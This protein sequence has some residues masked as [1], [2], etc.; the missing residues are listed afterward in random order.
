MSCILSIETSTNICSVAMGNDGECIFNQENH[1][2][3]NHN[4]ILGTFI[5]EALTFIDARNIKLDAVA[6]SSGPGSYT[7]LRI[8]AS[9]AKGICYGRDAKLIAVPTLELL[10]VPVLL[11]EQ[12]AEDDALLV[13]MLDARRMEVYA[14]VLDRALK[15]VRGIQAD[16]VTADTYREFLDGHEVYFFGNGAAKCMDTI[17]HPHAHLIKDVMPLA[18]NMFPLA[19]KRLAEGRVED[20]A[21]FVPFYLKDFVAK[22]P[23][24]LI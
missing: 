24:K 17:A 6:V 22:T 14:Q 7:G 23:K 10:A 4:E 16:V 19:E 11:G 3:P 2:G 5:D 8:G 15:E 20:V 1:Q 18:K 21:Y 13:P 9:M 12:V